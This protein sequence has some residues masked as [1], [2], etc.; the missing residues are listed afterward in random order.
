[1]RA[2]K[3]LARSW[4]SSRC[5]RSKSPPTLRRERRG[6]DEKEMPAR[7]QRAGSLENFHG[8]TELTSVLQWSKPHQALD[9]RAT[10]QLDDQVS[11]L[12]IADLERNKPEVAEYKHDEEME[13]FDPSLS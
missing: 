4:R 5:P 2:R 12:E 9:T 3:L 11:D 1:M 10:Q 8:L 7:E 6:T 13:G